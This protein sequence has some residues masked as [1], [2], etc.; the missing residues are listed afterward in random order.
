MVSCISV[1]AMIYELTVFTAEGLSRV[2]AERT[3]S[4]MQVSSSNP[5]VGI[6]GRSSLL[7]NLSA[8]LKANPIF[9]GANARPGGL[10]GTQF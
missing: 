8:A 2:T 1:T 10:V 4:A 7:T 6:D 5:M 9:F 3:A